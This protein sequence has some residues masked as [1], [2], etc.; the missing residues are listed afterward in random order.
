MSRL[1]FAAIRARISILEVLDLID[2]QPTQRQSEQWRGPCPFSQTLESLQ[3]HSSKQNSNRCF[4]VNVR[5]NVFRCFCCN[6]AG[7]SLDLWSQLTGKRLFDATQDLCEKLK[8][9]NNSSNLQ[10]ENS[11]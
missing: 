11:D 8:L 9:V 2:Y 1:D 3:Q 10:P 7:N 6:R 5:K 4:S